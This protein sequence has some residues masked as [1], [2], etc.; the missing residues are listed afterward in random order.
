MAARGGRSCRFKKKKSCRFKI[1]T[2]QK[3]VGSVFAGGG[4]TPKCTLNWHLIKGFSCSSIIAP[5]LVLN[6][7]ND[8]LFS[9]TKSQTQKSI[10][11]N[12]QDVVT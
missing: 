7:N 12:T 2:W 9:F 4:L 8:E 10:N 3:R 11:F 5:F 6:Y 1:R